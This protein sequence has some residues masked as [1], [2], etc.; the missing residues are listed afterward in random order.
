MLSIL[1]TAVTSPKSDGVSLTSQLMAAAA[2]LPEWSEEGLSNALI[3]S[4][5]DREVS[6][7]FSA[8]T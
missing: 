1:S 8:V 6:G 4:G 3:S 7:L 5:R 2:G